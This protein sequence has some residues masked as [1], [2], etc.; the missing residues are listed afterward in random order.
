MYAGVLPDLS[1]HDD[2]MVQVAFDEVARTTD[3]LKESGIRQVRSP[4]ASAVT[5]G[6][7]KHLIYS[8]YSLP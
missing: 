5:S 6:L 1:K 4:V 8:Y 2:A 3:S 7:I